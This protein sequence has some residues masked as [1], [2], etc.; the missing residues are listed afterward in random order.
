MKSIKITA[1]LS[2]LLLVAV[3]FFSSCNKTDISDNETNTEQTK[4]N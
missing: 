1:Y 4:Q 2:F 3:F